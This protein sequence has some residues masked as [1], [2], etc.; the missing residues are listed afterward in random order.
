MNI[1]YLSQ[2]FHIS[3]KDF[4]ENVKHRDAT[5]FQIFGKWHRSENPTF[6]NIFIIPKQFQIYVAI[7]HLWDRKITSI[8]GYLLTLLFTKIEW[9]R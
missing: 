5:K 2:G 9:P 6:I 1:G 8:H 3:H 7:V 4:Q